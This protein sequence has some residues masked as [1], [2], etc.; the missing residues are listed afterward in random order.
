MT[1]YHTEQKANR[2]KLTAGLRSGDY[3]QG[4]G[5]LAH[6]LLN[7]TWVYCCLGVGCVI[8]GVKGEPRSGGESVLLFHGS[9]THMPR[10]VMDFYGFQW[11]DGAFNGSDDVES[12]NLIRLNDDL[13][14]GFNAI[15]D[16][17]ETEPDGMFAEPPVN[18][19]DQMAV[20]SD[21]DP[22]DH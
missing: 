13:L 19:E 20:D 2:A 18:V 14:W 21:T 11:Q 17:I 10:E 5:K 16:L 7:G 6:R 8:A 9:S 1:D 4:R 15:A 3:K 22:T 12:S